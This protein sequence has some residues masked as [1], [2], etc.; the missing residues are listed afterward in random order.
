MISCR[1]RRSHPNRATPGIRSPAHATVACVAGDYRSVIIGASGGR[2]RHHALAYRHQRRA[3]LVAV[4]ARTVDK[5]DELADAY[6]VAARYDDY[7]EML[8]RERPDVVHVNTPPDARLELLEQIA[9]AGVPAAIIEKPIAID[10]PDCAALAAFARNSPLKVAVNH[11][12]HYHAPRQRLQ[13]LVADG[14]IGTVRFIDAST[15]MNAAYQGTHALQSVFAFAGGAQPAAVLGQ[16]SGTEGLQP[17]PRNHFAPDEL[18]AAIDFEGGLRAMLRC[19]AG[20][21]RLTE[22]PPDAR[23]AVWGHKRITVYGERGHV[24]WTMWSWETLLDGRLERG[25]HD[26]WEHDA[27]AESALVDSVLDWIESARSLREPKHAQRKAER[28]TEHDGN[29]STHPLALAEATAHY[30]VLLAAYRSAIE[31]RPLALPAADES[32]A[33]DALRAALSPAAAPS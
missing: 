5:R 4:S 28:E 13:T 10:G 16:A 3:K 29:R 24:T 25:V 22:A 31:R 17:S 21:P 6:G 8:A 18:L 1:F 30:A 27:P 15:G 11:Q 7:R 20:A 32:P 9:A 12:L 23:E 26:Y 14:A 2:A 19:G 33:I